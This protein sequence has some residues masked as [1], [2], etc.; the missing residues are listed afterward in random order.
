MLLSINTP[1]PDFTLYST[2]RDSVSLSDFKGKHYV[3]LI[4][5]P[6]DQTPGCTAQL[7]AIRDDYKEFET[8]NTRVFGVNPGDMKSHKK[9]IDK[10]RFQ[11][12]LLIDEDRAVAK[13]YGCDGWPMIRRT[14]YVID[15]EGTI[16]YAK[17]G[18][19]TTKELLEAI[20]QKTPD[21]IED[22]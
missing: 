3:V 5:Y 19:P 15:P 13:R 1:A 17:R 2:D 7:C 11:F 14:V 12:L 16:I 21:T 22:E 20:P 6:G 9:F 10:H 18:K 4:F 8:K